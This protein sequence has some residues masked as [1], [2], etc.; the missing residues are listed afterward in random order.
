MPTDNPDPIAAG[1]D[2]DFPSGTTGGTGIT[3]ASDSSFTLDGPGTYY[4]TFDATPAEAG[5]LVLTL[6]GAELP[7]TVVGSTAAGSR[8]VGQA[9][10]TTTATASTL[11]VRNPATATTSLTLT[12]SAGGTDPVSA[13]LTILRIA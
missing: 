5:Q 12:P 1:E 6:D 8:L 7:Y 13:H 11:T 10:V 2:V 4:V 9:L 3:R